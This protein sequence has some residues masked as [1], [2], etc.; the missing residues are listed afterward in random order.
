MLLF[1]R[2]PYVDAIRAG[3]KTFEIRCGARYRNVHIGDSLSI[4]GHFRVM[5]TSVDRY[6]TQ[7]AI[8]RAMPDWAAAIR[9][10]Y[11][12]ASGPYFVFHFNTPNAVANPPRS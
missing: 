12:D 9:D 4:N 5:V 7:R 2:K 6:A 10:C 3:S 8:V 11:A 1:V